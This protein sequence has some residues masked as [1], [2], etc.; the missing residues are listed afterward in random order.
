MKRNSLS[1][2]LVVLLMAGCSKAYNPIQEPL[3]EFD[4]Q[5]ESYRQDVDLSSLNPSK[6]TWIG[7]AV[8]TIAYIYA[9]NK[10]YATPLDT[11]NT[12]LINHQWQTMTAQQQFAWA[13]EYFGI[14]YNQNA[15]LLEE[16]E[17]PPKQPKS[18]ECPRM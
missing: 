4:G 10:Y 8:V 9:V 14:N 16:Y 11:D 5:E 17:E 12:L 7:I 13:A 18:I 1:L 3:I 6:G 15:L 2:I